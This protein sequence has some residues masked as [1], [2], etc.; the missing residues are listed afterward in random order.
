ML[1]Y[2]GCDGL[3]RLQSYLPAALGLL[4]NRPESSGHN[5]DISLTF[6]SFLSLAVVHCSSERTKI[7]KQNACVPQFS[8]SSAELST[9]CAGPLSNTPK[10]YSLAWIFASTKGTNLG[11]RDR[12]WNKHLFV[13]TDHKVLWSQKW[14]LLLKE[15][16]PLKW[17]ADNIFLT[18][19]PPVHIQYPPVISSREKL[20]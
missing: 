5:S 16:K 20:E 7:S 13:S 15:R 6:S 19:K 18:T 8:A 9:L 12:L 14:F 4:P 3:L 1:Q 11:E 17:K 10:W 2:L